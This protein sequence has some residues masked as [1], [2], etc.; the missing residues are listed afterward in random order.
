MFIDEIGDDSVDYREM[1]IQAL[2]KCERGAP[3]PIVMYGAG[4]TASRVEQFLNR[5]ELEVSARFVDD[6]FLSHCGQDE[7]YSLDQI[8]MKYDRFNCVLGIWDYQIPVENLRRKECGQI[9]GIYAF[10]TLFCDLFANLRN[11]IETNA[12][13]FAGI[14]ELF[15]DDLSRRAYVNFIN[16]KLTGD[17]IRFCSAPSPNMYFPPD[18][19][20]LCGHESFVDG[21]AYTGDTLQAF[22][23]KVHEKYSSYCAIEPDP[24]NF[25]KLGRYVNELK[26]ANISL[27]EKGL[28]YES[29]ILRFANTGN[30]SSF[31]KE[32]GGTEVNVDTVDNL[33]PQATFIKLDIEGV[34]L[35]ALKGAVKTIMANRPKLAICLYHRPEHLIDVPL[36]IKSLVPKYK[37]FLRQ[38]ARTTTDLVLYAVV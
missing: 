19:V 12:A 32:D 2:K 13:A 9:A 11:Y 34:E 6:E 27:Y 24:T 25:L 21:G 8:L 20:V 4:E 23:E 14:Y 30:A 37:L 3:L 28:W 5:R 1:A 33:C 10:D 18:V 15:E 16:A 36:F 26:I 17:Q 38:H 22:I 31:I 29:R 7:L 35:E